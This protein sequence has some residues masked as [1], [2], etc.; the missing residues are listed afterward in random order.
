VNA[1]GPVHTIDDVA[2]HAEL[3]QLTSVFYCLK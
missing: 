1:A 2:W 3:E